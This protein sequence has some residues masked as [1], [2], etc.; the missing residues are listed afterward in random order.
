MVG[1][2]VHQQQVGVLRQRA[3]DLRAASLTPACALGFAAHVDP[4]L[5]GDRLYLVLF[6]RVFAAQR[7][8]HQRGVAGKVGVLFQHHDPRAGLHLALPLV[9]L[10]PIIDQPE[11]R[12]L[13]HPIAPDQRQTVARADVQ[14]DIVLVGAAEQPATALLQAEIF[15]GKNWRLSHCC[16]ELRRARLSH[17]PSCK[18]GLRVTDS[19]PSFMGEYR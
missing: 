15:P 14:V 19:M 16:G 3:G 18:R 10:Q 5:P 8:V 13:A 7:E 1:R 17:K 9:G 11:Q 6:G 12:G 2:L 4:E